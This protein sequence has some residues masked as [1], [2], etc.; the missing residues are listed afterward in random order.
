MV[1]KI[2]I[3]GDKEAETPKDLQA[4][5]LTTLLQG[6]YGKGNLGAVKST[7][8]ELYGF[9][10]RCECPTCGSFSDEYPPVFFDE[11]IEAAMAFVSRMFEFCQKQD[12]GTP[13]DPRKVH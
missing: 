9:A 10:T 8:G 5:F 6:F 13:T 12:D 7:E 2:N 1:E 11:P 3:V 4:L